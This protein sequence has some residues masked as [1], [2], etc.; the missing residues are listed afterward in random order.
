MKKKDRDRDIFLRDRKREIKNG[1]PCSAIK[2][3]EMSLRKS[4]GKREREREK[5][6]EIGNKERREEV[7]AR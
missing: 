4:F 5:T 1:K 2:E 7:D 3:R 6:A